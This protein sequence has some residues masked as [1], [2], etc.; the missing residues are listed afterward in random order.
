[1]LLPDYQISP[2][3]LAEWKQSFEQLRTQLDDLAAS[4]A[5]AEGQ[6]LTSP[7]GPWCGFLVRARL[8]LDHAL[9]VFADVLQERKGRFE[10]Q[11]LDATPE[12]KH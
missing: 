8:S 7:A 9:A 11:E 6:E 3:Q 10:L 4:I 12:P 5:L 2:P 1:M